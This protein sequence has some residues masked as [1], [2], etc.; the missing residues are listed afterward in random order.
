MSD[1]INVRKNY[2]TLEKQEQFDEYSKVV[3]VVSDENNIGYSAGTDTGRTLTLNCPFGTQQ[4]AEDILEK[5]QGYQYQ[6]YSATGAHID[7]AVEIGDGITVGGIY[8][9]LFTKDVTHG[10]LYTAD[11]SAPGG[12]KINYA[13]PFKTVQEREIERNFRDV[14]ARFSVQA[15]RILQEVEERKEQGEIF[16][17]QFQVQSAQISAKVENTGGDGGSFG[18]TLTDDSWTLTS[19]GGT[20]LTVNKDGLEVKGKINATSG[21]ICGFTIEPDYLSFNNQEWRG[22][23]TA[24]IYIG[25]QGL[26]LGANFR[27]DMYGNLSASSGHFEGT[28]LAKNIMYADS[29]GGV[30]HIIDAGYMSGAALEDLSVY[31]GKITGATL[32]TAKFTSGVNTTLGY[33]DYSNGVFNGWNTAPTIRTQAIYAENSITVAGYF[34]I[35]HN[36][37][38]KI[39]YIRDVT[40]D[41]TTYHVLTV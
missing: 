12:E 20:V 25:P 37:S 16:K 30:G 19:N 36:G 3:I 10:P 38:N 41:G 14:S 35:N 29:N 27:V 28:I 11:V 22:T 40:I 13:Y 34:L 23:N 21:K 39:V 24:G 6:P 5:V 4:M 8:G 31:G 32:S 15:D 17:A 26:Q 7:P 1:T 33:A 9:G 2:A 18:W